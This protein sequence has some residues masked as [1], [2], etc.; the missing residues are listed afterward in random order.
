[1]VKKII[2]GYEHTFESKNYY[3]LFELSRDCSMSDIR[4]SYRRISLKLHPD[5]NV[6]TNAAAE[7]NE[8][9]KVYDVSIQF[10]ILD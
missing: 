8:A 4:Q 9:K 6:A 7:F 3:Q 2:Q 1:M 5:K 10:F